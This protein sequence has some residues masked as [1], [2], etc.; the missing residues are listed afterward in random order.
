M[1]AGRRSSSQLDVPAL[2]RE[3]LALEGASPR[4][5]AD[6]ILARAVE[7]DRNRPVDDISVVVV[8]VSQMPKDGDGVRRLAVDL[9]V[10]VKQAI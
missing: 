6:A 7:C 8:G 3:Q 10:W 2:V 4:T 5:L 9:P 1:H